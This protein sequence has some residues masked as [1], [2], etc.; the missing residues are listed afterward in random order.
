MLSHL[1]FSSSYL[2][3]N[4]FWPLSIPGVSCSENSRRGQD[5]KFSGARSAGHAT[6]L[7]VHADPRLRSCGGRHVSVPDRGVDGQV[8]AE[9]DHSDGQKLHRDLCLR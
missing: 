7:P 5:E 8:G 2:V 9:A 1:Q 6:S 4:Y 3:F